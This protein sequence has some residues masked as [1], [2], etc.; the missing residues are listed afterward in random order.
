MTAG[1]PLSVVAFKGS[2]APGH[3][4]DAPMLP[5]P[6]R[7][8][9]TLRR[10]LSGWLVTRPRP[11]SFDVARVDREPARMRAL[12]RVPL[13]AWAFVLFAIGDVVWYV[14][15]VRLE[16]GSSISDIT[17]YAFQVIPSIAAILL[18]AALL[19]RHPDALSRARTL[20]FGTILFA[21]V[22]GLLIL[23][24][25]LQGFFE[26]V[27]PP[28][29]DVPSLVPLAALYNGLISL[30]AA[31]GFAYI[32]VGLSQARRYEDRSGSLTTLFVPVAAVFATVVGVLA[33]SRLQLG[34]TAMS[35]T[36]AIYL[37]ASVVLGILRIVAWAYLATV[38]TRGW[39]AGEDPT[40]GWGLGALGGGLVILALA[41]VNLDGVLDIGEATFLT[42]YGYVIVLAYA[43]GHVGVLAAFAVGLPALDGSED[44]F[45][46]D[47]ELEDGHGDLD[48]EEYGR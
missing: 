12:G 41:L 5:F 13:L 35:P 40:G 43:F 21:L 27:T 34:D 1:I 6:V 38:A 20:V 31:F 2:G 22:Q 42:V 15:S 10:P 11:V 29:E 18:P 44:E 30:V 8:A 33:V 28:S 48:E 32:A 37:A 47:A 19:A 4:H 39:L 24:E 17:V 46:D 26:S 23:T 3:R 14:G 16:A 9:N 45:A 7:P 25:P 36:L